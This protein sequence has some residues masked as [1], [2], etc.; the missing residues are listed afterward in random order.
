MKCQCGRMLATIAEFNRRTCNICHVTVVRPE[1]I[2]GET[3]QARW[4]R[5]NPDRRRK[6]HREG[7]RRR[8]AAAS[9]AQADVAH[10]A[11]VANHLMG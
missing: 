3:R 4:A 5:L 10:V 9:E 1:L 6:I 8:R 2:D 11:K 7:Q